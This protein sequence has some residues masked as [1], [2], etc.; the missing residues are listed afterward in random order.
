MS[1]KEFTIADMISAAKGESPSEFQSAFD[2]LVVDKVAAVVD[3]AKLEVA[4]NYFNTD[5]EQSA[6]QQEVT[7]DE[8][9]E[10]SAGSETSEE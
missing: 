3:A 5:D 2:A 8:N 7:T 4:K 9:T 1:D 10:A 6:E